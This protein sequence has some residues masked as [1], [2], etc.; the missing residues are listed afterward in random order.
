M[1]TKGKILSVIFFILILLGYFDYKANQVKKSMDKRLEDL[2]NSSLSFQ[3]V[4]EEIH[5]LLFSHH[6][7]LFNYDSLSKET[8][9]MMDDNL[10]EETVRAFKKGAN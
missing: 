2:A 8:K 3:K 7:T 5:R 1:T 10:S 9:K 6:D 4:D